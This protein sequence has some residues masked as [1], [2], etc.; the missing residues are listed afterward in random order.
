M[1]LSVLYCPDPSWQ[2][3]GRPRAIAAEVAVLFVC[4]R[5]YTFAPSLGSDS[6]L[7]GREQKKGF[8]LFLAKKSWHLSSTMQGIVSHLQVSSVHLPLSSLGWGTTKGE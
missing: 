4:C 2:A 6:F 1:K 7:Q 8:G 5:V 3:G